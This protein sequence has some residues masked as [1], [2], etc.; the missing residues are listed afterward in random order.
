MAAV[1]FSRVR[2]VVIF[3]SLYRYNML[4]SYELRNILLSTSHLSPWKWGKQCRHRDLLH[5]QWKRWNCNLECR[6][7]LMWLSSCVSSATDNFYINYLLAVHSP[8]E[9][10]FWDKNN[11][12]NVKTAKTKLH[13]FFL[14]A[15]I[16]RLLRAPVNEEKSKSLIW[17]RVKWF[18]N[19]QIGSFSR[20]EVCNHWFFARWC[21]GGKNSRILF[22][23]G[24]VSVLVV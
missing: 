6:L 12:A 21:S 18:L 9:S 20:L 14:K 10:S 22:I 17:Q 4:F 23:S 24:L 11:C 15:C 19:G 5:F 13:F 16:Q 7:L 3:I 8:H 2:R 1:S